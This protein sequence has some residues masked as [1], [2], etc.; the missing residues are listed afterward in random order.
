MKSMPKLMIWSNLNCDCYEF[1]VLTIKLVWTDKFDYNSIQLES[2]QLH[3]KS[4]ILQ[5]G[6]VLFMAVDSLP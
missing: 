6:L 4:N 3:Y 2:D 1:D 5:T